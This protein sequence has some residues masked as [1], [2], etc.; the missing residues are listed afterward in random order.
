MCGP[1]QRLWD[2]G[3][4][5]RSVAIFDMVRFFAHKGLGL[6]ELTE[7]VLEWDDRGERIGQA[8]RSRRRSLRRQGPR[9]GARHCA[10]RRLHRAAVPLAPEDRLLQGERRAD[11]A[12]RPLRRRLRHREG[13]RS[14]ARRHARARA[15]VPAQAHPR[16][17]RAPRP[18]GAV[19]VPRRRR[20]ALRAEGQGP[21]QSGRQ[22]S[23]HARA[24]GRRG[25]RS[26]E[27]RRGHGGRD[28]RGRVLLL[29]HD[30]A[31]RVEGHLVVHH[32]ADDARP[33]RGRRDDLRRRA[34]RQA[35][36]GAGATPP[37]HRV[38]QQARPHSP[39]PVR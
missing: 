7:L 3:A 37:A 26:R 28:L 25:H 23:H 19:E 39:A 8:A 30:R 24:R 36:Q 1:V 12:V 9:E 4:E 18:V 11:G 38:S 20:E 6:D 34:H 16:R 27:Q 29:L 10:R 35:R 33:H 13:D 31:R 17:H 21:A 32:R 15:G 5:D 22:G 2:H 14:R